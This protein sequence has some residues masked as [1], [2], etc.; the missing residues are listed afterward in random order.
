MKDIFCDTGCRETAFIYAITSAALAHSVSRACSAGS[1]YTCS[2]GNHEPV[3]QRKGLGR[4]GSL[5]P[6]GPQG[7]SRHSTDWQWGGCGDNVQFGH[8]FA[9]DFVDA[10]ERERDLRC[11]MNLH[12]NEAGRTVSRLLYSVIHHSRE[13]FVNL[14]WLIL[15]KCAC[16]SCHPCVHKDAWIGVNRL[17]HCFSK[18]VV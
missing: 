15:I 2:C 8:R 1:I 3:L 7:T 17:N 6:G 11:A 12:N 16:T 5:S 13:Y 14:S 9:R 4:R 18:T 10:N